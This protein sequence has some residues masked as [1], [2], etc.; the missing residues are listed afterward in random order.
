MTKHRILT[1]LLFF[2]LHIC[3]GQKYLPPTGKRMLVIGQD[4]GSIQ[5]YVS[6]G[7]FPTPSG[8]TSYV[9]FYNL[10]NPSAYYP[11]GGLGEKLD[12]TVAS[13]IDWGAG[14]L[15]THN[16]ALGYP[17]SILVF[18]LS[19]TEDYA[20]NGLTK[21]ANGD[22][23]AEITRLANF[24]KDKKKPVFVRIGYEFD[25]HWNTGYSN[26]TNYKNAYK[27]I[28]DII[29]PIAPNFVSVWQACTSPIDD[30]IEGYHEDISTWYPG[31]DYVDW[32]AYSWFLS[33]TQQISLT[34]EL[35]AY[36]KLRGKPVMVAESTPQGY[37][38]KNLTHRD[39]STLIDG[40][41]GTN[42]VSKTSDQIWN[43][44]FKPYFDYIH[45]NSDVI[46]A[47]AYINANWDAQAQWGSPYNQGYW[48]DSRTE[49]NAD[50]RAKWLAEI[51][52]TAWLPGSATLFT[53]L[54][55]STSITPNQAPVVSFTSPSN[56]QQFT[57]GTNLTVSAS[58]TD[59]DTITMVKLFLNSTLVRSDL[60]APYQWG[61]SGQ[62]D[63]ALQNV[64]VGTYTL[65]LEATDKHG[66]TSSATISISV[67]DSTV[68]TTTGPSYAPA[69]GKTLLLI[70]Q[71]YT[72]E[73]KDYVSATKKAPAGSSHYG[74]IYTGKINQ[75]D[76]ASNES[77]LTYIETNYPLAYSELAISIK[78]NPAAGGY[79]PSAPNVVWQVCQDISAGKW[80][81]E[82]DLISQSMK[83]RPT[84]KFLVRID[85]EVSLTM[86]A[87]KTSTPFS[88]I[89]D[90][91]NNMGVNPLENA[92]KVT[93][94]DL[95]AYPNAFNYIAKRIRETNGVSNA[96]FVFHTVR[97]AND[98]KWL[99]PGDK[100]VDWYGVSV[101]NHDVC[102]PTWEPPYPFVN[103]P[104]TQAVDDNL[105]KCLDWASTVVKKPIIISESA[106]QAELTNQHNATFMNSY[107]DKVTSLIETY[108]IKAWVYINSNWVGHNWSAQWGDSRIETIS[109]VKN[110]W[111]QKVST[112]R[113]IHYPTLVTSVEEEETTA[114][115]WKVFPNPT[116]DLL[117]I[118]SGTEEI[119]VQL[120]DGL[121]TTIFEKQQNGNEALSLTGLSSGMYYLRLTSNGKS[122]VIP[123]VKN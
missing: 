46:R 49:V 41:P 40:S 94:F 82:I 112:S 70:G 58:A 75:G 117:Y 12:G 3:W 97:G 91:Y 45:T 38:L 88:Q 42:S 17:N 89:L 74:E 99:Y 79:D 28:V 95:T 48:G 62:N 24:I 92:D 115:A 63:V 105:K 50:I 27:R 78:D 51:E 31:D 86:F 37:D 16:A 118:A 43:E 73:Y 44:W 102:E 116:R 7:Y 71:T 35:I 60:V 110:Y 87:N 69:A 5:N 61:M 77:F 30:I 83:N 14:P 23:D 22:Y 32:M 113:Y 53:Q 119:H 72:Q 34:D 26:T 90:K 57:K 85:Y 1:A 111:L 18:G 121:G 29:R 84:L 25:G 55:D 2:C 6:S 81:D 47:V 104:A 36:A 101:F 33:S 103:C 106:V 100:Y 13:D 59:D 54:S 76:D 15:N 39:I 65:R 108:D 114:A 21:I 56:N 4:L 8:V 98:A 122:Q 9:D 52:G 11:F 93:E 80:D 68:S 67:V 107:L 123:V 19:M 10:A 96:A 109:D 64:A 66:H 120:I 20:P